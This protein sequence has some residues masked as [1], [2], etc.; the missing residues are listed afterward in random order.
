[1]FVKNFQIRITSPQYRQKK[2]SQFNT[3][4]TESQTTANK[5]QFGQRINLEER[6]SKNPRDAMVTQKSLTFDKT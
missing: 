5:K 4:N 1:M 6:L 3:F 2:S